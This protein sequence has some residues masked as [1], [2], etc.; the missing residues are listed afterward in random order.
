MPPSWPCRSSKHLSFEDREEISRSLALRRSF[1]AIASRLERPT[2]TISREV[3]RNGGRHTYRAGAADR[4]TFERAKR[5]RKSVF[6]QRP[7][8]AF[9]VEN[10]LQQGMSPEQIC[11]RLIVEFPD[12][13][14]MRV[15]PET[16]YQAL[17]VQGRG[18]LNKELVKCLRTRRPRRKPHAVTARNTSKILDKVMIGDRPAEIEDR[19]VPGHWEGD[20]IIGKG[21][22]SQLG[23]LVERTTGFVLLIQL[24]DDRTAATVAAALQRQIK[25]LPPRPPDRSPGTRASKWHVMPA[26]PSIPASPSTSVIPTR[27]GSAAQARTPT[28]CFANTSP[29]APISRSIPK[30]TSTTSPPNSTTDH[31][32][33]TAF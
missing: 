21:G 27:L 19:A 14:T 23:T 17:F 25:T 24:P 11:G 12:D 6:E 7:V 3:N 1:A 8:L 4:A 22:R 9:V 18:G 32:N 13:D 16:I 28:G 31:A 26:S 10:W 30:P 2:S 33:D 15:V 20:L 29:T 5:T